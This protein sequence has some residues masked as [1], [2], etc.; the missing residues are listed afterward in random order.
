[1]LLRHPH[2]LLRIKDEVVVGGA[3]P[4]TVPVSWQVCIPELIY[5]GFTDI[6]YAAKHQSGEKTK[7]LVEFKYELRG[8]KNCQFL[9]A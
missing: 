5:L 7:E 6:Y 1:M 8:L 9:I 4:R 3:H 2:E